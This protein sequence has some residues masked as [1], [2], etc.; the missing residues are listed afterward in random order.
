V[1]RIGEIGS[2]DPDAD[3]VAGARYAAQ[4]VEHGADDAFALAVYGHAQSFLLHDFDKAKVVLERAI[5]AG[6][7]SAMAWTMASATSGFLGDGP[8]AVRQGE[9]GVRLSPLDARSFWHE[10]LLGQAH[11]VNG[12]YEQALEWARGAVSRNGLIRFNQRLLIVTLDALGRREEAAEAARRL[13]HIQPDFGISAYARRCPFRG[14]A[15]ETWLG[16]LRSAGL[17]D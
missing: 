6:P 2:P 13:L 11:Y 15:L 10:G 5:A 8:A 17:P 3:A 14:A 16:H 7:S 1:F 9:Q 12:D 4:A